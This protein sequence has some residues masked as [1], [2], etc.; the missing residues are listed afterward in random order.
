MFK[1]LGRIV[2]KLFKIEIRFKGNWQKDYKWLLDYK[3]NTILDIGANEGQYASKMRM[4]FPEAK[5][6]SFEPIPNVYQILTNNFKY[7]VN[8]RAY[9]I[10]LGGENTETEFFENESSASSSLLKMKDHTLHFNHA[11]QTKPI[12]ITVK[13]LDEVLANEPL[14]KPI[15]VKIDVQGFEDQVIAGGRET[16]A[17][18]DLILCEV[19]FAQLYEGQKLFNNIY[20]T[21]SSLGFSY[22]GNYEQLHSP[23]NNAILQADA[24]FIKKD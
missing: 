12:T 7:D 18:A 23:A 2:F 19:S 16:L 14:L 20:E 5:I 4:F 15:M 9:P 8:F 17:K 3:F 1:L 11:T 21:L 22:A 10:G 24:I 6:L 13:R